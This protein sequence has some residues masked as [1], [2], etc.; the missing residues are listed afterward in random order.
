[1]TQFSH[2]RIK[3]FENCSLQFKYRYILKPEVPTKEN[4]EAF[5]GKRF[6]ETM[7]MLY[8][9]QLFGI[10]P[11]IEELNDFFSDSWEK[12]WTDSVKIIKPDLTMGDYKSYGFKC[13]ENYY[14]CFHPFNQGTT[15]GIERKILV[16]LNED[17]N[18]IGFV[19]RITKLDDT[20][21]QI[22]DY[23]TGMSMP[24]K[25][26]LEQDKQLALYAYALK[27]EFPETE[28]IDL[29]WH[30]VGF[31]QTFML[32][33]SFDE[34]EKIKN[35]TLEAALKILKAT[36]FKPSRSGL[37]SYCDYV[38]ICPEWKQIL[39]VQEMEKNEFLNQPAVKLADKYTEL[40][41][42]K[43]AF[44]EK[45]DEELKKI[46]EALYDYA[47]KNNVTS[48]QGSE[49]ILRLWS[50]RNVSLPLKDSEE[51][52]EF[53][54]LLE[55]HGLLEQFQTFDRFAFSR[56]VV[57]LELPEEVRK[58]LDEISEP[59]QVRRIY[60]SSFQKEEKEK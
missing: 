23:K 28:K 40:K 20:H 13:I 21:L 17:I 60:M 44:D 39:S 5:L 46:E 35:E 24:L 8:K 12:N 4:I 47:D 52:E 34:L 15:I 11:S 41:N 27:Q 30:F 10:V 38:S 7:E 43:K 31:G 59:K 32:S 9:K 26:E 16:S 48:I 56:A 45:A 25:S 36:E 55:K 37:C 3:C 51:L 1:M 33:K 57:G 42:K 14:S 22:H 49:A 19:D 18:L 50:G 2:S 58:K 54:S 53:L 6:H 29:V